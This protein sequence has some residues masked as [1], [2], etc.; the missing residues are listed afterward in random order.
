MRRPVGLLAERDGS[1][2]AT[3]CPRAV[4]ERVTR[5]GSFPYRLLDRMNVMRLAGVNRSSEGPLFP[6][7]AYPMP[8]QSRQCVHVQY[9]VHKL[10]GFRQTDGVVLF[11]DACC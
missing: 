4:V 11:A 7:Y 10:C 2:P 6:P 8:S 5:L 3:S 9:M 1:Q